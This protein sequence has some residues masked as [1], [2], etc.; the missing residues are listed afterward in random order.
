MHQL[1]RRP[2]PGRSGATIRSA[3]EYSDRA[4]DG[5]EVMVVHVRPARLL[6]AA[7][8]TAAL[9][10]GSLSAADS[11]AGPPETQT[12]D[13]GN[14][15]TL[16]LVR[17]PAG[18]GTV[19]VPTDAPARG[20]ADQDAH[21][22]T[23]A[24]DFLLGTT[25]VTQAQYQQVMGDNPTT[26][27]ALNP[28]KRTQMVGPE[29]PV[30]RVSLKQAKEFCA[31]LGQKTGRRVRL[32]TDEEWEYAAR[33]G[34]DGLSGR[35]LDEVAWHKGNSGEQQHPVATK[36]GSAWGLHDMIGNVGEWVTAAKGNYIVGGDWATKP[37]NCRASRRAP[38]GA[39]HNDAWSGFRVLVEAP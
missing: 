2:L 27:E 39:L 37:E 36:P 25:E 31:K 30:V 1:L 5:V 11:P 23:I 6:T 29:Y 8:L 17:I 13:L 16:K 34:G 26:V 15:L 21:E 20:K 18:T 19:G 38:H 7:L 28:Q 32:P 10:T 24:K 3:C 12:L 35:P 9:L 33:A 14:D 4:I 22:V